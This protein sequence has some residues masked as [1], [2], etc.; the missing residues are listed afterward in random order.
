VGSVAVVT[1]ITELRDAQAAH[2]AVDARRQRAE[3][4]LDTVFRTSPDA[5][6]LF[7]ADDEVIVDVNDA[8]CR[9]TGYSREEVVG[10][11][12]KELGLWEDPADSD[13][14]AAIIREHGSV[15][16][17]EFGFHRHGPGGTLEE[18]VAVL[19]ARPAVVDG[20]TYLLCIGRDVTLERRQERERRQI[21]KLED[22]GRLSGGIAHDFN[23]LLAVIHSYAENARYRAASGAP[24]AVRDMDELL[25]AVGRATTLTG[26]LLKFSRSAPVEPIRLRLDEVVASAEGLLKPL[27]GAASLRIDTAGDLPE[28]LADPS[29]VEQVLLNLVINARDAMP[30]GG[31]ITVRTRAVTVPAGE[32]MAV[33]GPDV[34]PGEFA[35]L[36]VADEGSGMSEEVR[37]R[38]FEPF[39]TTK[40][41]GK[42]TGLGL[43]VVHGIV[44]QAHGAIRVVSAPG[45]GSVFRIFWPAAP[46]QASAVAPAEP[47]RARQ[48]AAGSLILLVEDDVRVRSAVQRMLEAEGLRVETAAN[49]VEAL[50]W[51]AAARKR[52]TCASL[53]L[54]DVRMPL[55]DGPALARRLFQL[56]PRLPVLLI[57]GDGEVPSASLP[58]PACEVLAKPFT[59]AELSR[60]VRLHMAPQ[61]VAG[62]ELT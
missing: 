40:G 37:S 61:P 49:G 16:A 27:L 28:V 2:Q 17:F 25:A 34:E 36:E 53:V 55:M 33:V 19:A 52:G 31:R 62:A 13:R 14:L 29:Q 48:S 8:W 7:R 9:T 3:K 11:S 60:A 32:V 47:E 6:V 4:L 12:Q 20:V 44:R 56:D 23:N 35:V 57:T 21:Q 51:L 59:G 10:R 24:V 30:N 39:F 5:M 38:I 43:A 26:R 1:D 50:E 58:S 41:N 54:S 22:L 45:R 18:G 46:A 15:A 42:G